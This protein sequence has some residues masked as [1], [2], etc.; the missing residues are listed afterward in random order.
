MRDKQ[1]RRVV[2]DMPA[3]LDVTAAEITLVEIYMRDVIAGLIEPR[4][5]QGERVDA[6][7]EGSA[8]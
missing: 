3:Q 7:P 2:L 6:P 8:A 4:E 1:G 5:P